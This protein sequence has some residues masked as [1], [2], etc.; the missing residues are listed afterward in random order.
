MH[1]RIPAL[2]VRRT[3][4]KLFGILF[5][6]LHFPVLCNRRTDGAVKKRM[7]YF[8]LGLRLMK[9]MRGDSSNYFNR[10]LNAS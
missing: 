7:L 9:E 8:G 5:K 6:I 10:S 3:Q 2:S 4:N 1:L